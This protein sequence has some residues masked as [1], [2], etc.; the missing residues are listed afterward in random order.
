MDNYI[1]TIILME[2]ACSDIPSKMSQEISDQNL[3][4]E[5]LTKHAI[6]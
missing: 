5:K 6:E 2:N 4:I 3:V 1:T